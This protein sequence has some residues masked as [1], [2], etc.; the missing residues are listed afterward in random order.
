MIAGFSRKVL[1]GGILL[2]HFSTQLARSLPQLLA[3]LAGYWDKRN[4]LHLM[5]PSCLAD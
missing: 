5:N 2:L 1:A 3:W 4:G